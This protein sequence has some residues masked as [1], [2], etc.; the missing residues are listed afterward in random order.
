MDGYRDGL[1]LR[2]TLD[3]PRARRLLRLL[4]PL[5]LF[6]T[7]GAFLL[8][9]ALPSPVTVVFLLV[10]LV[11]YVLL[12]WLYLRNATVFVRDEMFGKTDLFGRVTAMRVADI[13]SVEEAHPYV[14]TAVLHFVDDTGSVRLK[15]FPTAYTDEQLSQLRQRLLLDSRRAS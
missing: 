11:D 6:T 10:A 15:L 9:F 12:P 8:A 7:V 5:A 13:R 14:R 4:G 3:A 2:P 1:V